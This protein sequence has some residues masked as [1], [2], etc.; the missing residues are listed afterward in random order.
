MTT[1][2]PNTTD[3]GRTGHTEPEV[4]D[5]VDWVVG[6]FAALVGTGMAAGGGIAYWVLDRGE[7]QS[8]V[9]GVPL[10][11]VG[12][13]RTELVTATLPALE[14][15]FIGIVATGLVLVVG[16]VGFVLSRRRT[17]RAAARGDGTPGTVWAHAVYGA[18]ASAL[19]PVAPLSGLVGG[20]VAG[21]LE[22]PAR[23]STRAG[24]I[25]GLLGV[26]PAV[27]ILAA[28]AVGVVV[29]ASAI[30]E[31]SAGLLI[32]GVGGSVVLAV[33]VALGAG[34]GALGGALA[35]RPV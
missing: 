33:L 19:V 17:R 21:Y 27:G 16:G 34:L 26:V 2:R 32:G 28:G 22:P 7:L 18:A 31:L 35:D 3:T 11:E 13:T 14:W 23:S 1:E 9:T 12:L 30:G 5:V 6:L 15:L 8:G 24:A 20:G 25:A 10:P 29:G 4:P